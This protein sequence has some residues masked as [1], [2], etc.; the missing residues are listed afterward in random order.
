[1]ERQLTFLPVSRAEA[2]SLASGA[3]VPGPRPAFAATDALFITQGLAPHDEEEGEYAAMVLASVWGLAHYGE[4]VVL[5]AELPPGLVAEPDPD[6]VEADN[7]GVSVDSVPADAVVSWFDD[8]PEA[9]DAVRAAAEAARGLSVD[10]AWDLPPVQALV[11]GHDLLWHAAGE[12]A[13]AAP[14]GED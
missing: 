7:G 5:V 12:L 8:E 10:E 2:A 14:S 6:D 3:A 13:L 11:T 9:A 4:R 1:M